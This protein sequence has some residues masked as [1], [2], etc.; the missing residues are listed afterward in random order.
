MKLILVLLAFFGC[1][2]AGAENYVNLSAGRTEA[3][4]FFGF[5]RFAFPDLAQGGPGCC[6]QVDFTDESAASYN[7]VLG[8]TFSA[9]FGVEG[10]LAYLGNYDSAFTVSGPFG[11]SVL[12]AG[13]GY[14]EESGSFGFASLTL[15]GT[16]RATVAGVYIVPKIGASA[17]RMEFETQ[18]HCSLAGGT[19]DVHQE[20]HRT[21]LAPMVGVLL[22]L[23]VSKVYSVT[24]SAEKR[25]NVA[26]ANT[27]ESQDYRQGKIELTSVWLGF[28]RRF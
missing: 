9:G 28:E 4:E 20:D 5:A 8:K 16:Y 2:L 27:Q 1:S 23:P 10:G 18:S 22:S 21:S 15:A 14:C 13:P 6:N 19:V 25:Y 26:I 12:G 3:P 24:L 17:V 11:G 7:L